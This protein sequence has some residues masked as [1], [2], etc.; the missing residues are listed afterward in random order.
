MARAPFIPIA[1]GV[2]TRRER[3]LAANL[4]VTG[5]SLIALAAG[6]WV[7][8]RAFAPRTVARALR[9]GLVTGLI[10]VAL[11]VVTLYAMLGEAMDFHSVGVA[12]GVTE[13][14]ASDVNGLP[15]PAGPAGR[16]YDIS[17]PDLARGRTVTSIAF[18]AT[19]GVLAVRAAGLGA[20]AGSG[21]RRC[22]G[23]RIY[24][25]SPSRSSSA[26]HWPDSGIHQA[27]AGLST[28]GRRNVSVDRTPSMSASDRSSATSSGCDR[29][30]T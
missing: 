17:P 29:T 21:Q 12:L 20:T 13:I 18:V 16:E 26:L 10:A 27:V 7:A 9:I 22:G 19:W 23:Q 4:L 28:S 30:T 24:P 2:S 5:S 1:G 8:G 3:A 25:S 6:G 11:I 15:F 14:P